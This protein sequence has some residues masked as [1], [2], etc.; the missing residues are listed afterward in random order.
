MDWPQAKKATADVNTR[1]FQAAEV[2]KL[3]EFRKLIEYAAA[4]VN[5]TGID[6]W[7]A[8][9]FASRY[10]HLP[11]VNYLLKQPIQIDALSKSRWTPL[12][13]ACERGHY[14]IAEML[15]T[16]GADFTITDSD[17]HTASYH[18]QQKKFDD[19]V[20][21]ITEFQQQPPEES[22]PPSTTQQSASTEQ[23]TE[24]LKT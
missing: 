7:T 8:L 13:L 9:H 20:D 19:I 23:S 5:A 10:G 2:G 17:G 21:L 24:A 11:I 12:H 16:C 6:N 3:G 14:E 22:A 1:L 4:D 15:L 18:A